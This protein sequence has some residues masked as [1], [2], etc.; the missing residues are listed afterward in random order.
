MD[1]FCVCVVLCLG[2][3]LVTGWSLAQGVLPSV[4]NDY[5]TKEEA[6]ALNGL[7]EPPKKSYT[8]MGCPWTLHSS[9]L[10]PHLRME[11]DSV[12]KTLYSLVSRIQDNGQSNSEC[13]TPLSEPFRICLVPICQTILCHIQKDC[14]LNIQYHEKIRSQEMISPCTSTIL[15]LY[16]QPTRA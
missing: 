15:S 6:R 9:C 8:D 11:T 13:Y 3:G 2:R 14:N 12:S 7:E 5:G 1:L 4:K 10:P 16:S